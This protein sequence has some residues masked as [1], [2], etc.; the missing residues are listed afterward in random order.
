ME[1]N[2][3][4]SFFVYLKWLENRE[5]NFLKEKDPWNNIYKKKMFVP[6]IWVAEQITMPP[7]K[8]WVVYCKLL[9]CPSVACTNF[10]AMISATNRCIAFKFGTWFYKRWAY[11]VSEF[12]CWLISTSW[13]SL[14][15]PVITSCFKYTWKKT[16][17]FIQS[18][19]SEN[20]SSTLLPFIVHIFFIRNC[21]R[22]WTWLQE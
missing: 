15:I 7:L 1:W 3:S 10:V 11:I 20:P 8:E 9:V 22:Q 2:A 19:I 13:I 5:N 12:D 6:L 16:N 4:L 17:I 18:G 21:W 14:G